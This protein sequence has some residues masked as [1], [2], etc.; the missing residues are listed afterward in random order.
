MKEPQIP[1]PALE[2]ENSIEMARVWIAQRGLHCS[3]K[4]GRYLETSN[5][6][7][8]KAWGILLA[9]IARHVARA[10]EGGYAMDSAAVLKGIR[11]SF[12]REL[13]KPTSKVRGGFTDTQ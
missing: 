9:D 5:V 6:A 3:L 4:V 8:E 2:D 7:E 12:E 13:D 10:L 1:G 11:E